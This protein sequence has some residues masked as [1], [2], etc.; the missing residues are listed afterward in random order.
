MTHLKFSLSLTSGNM[1]RNAEDACSRFH[2]DPSDRDRRHLIA[3][4]TSVDC[5]FRGRYLDRMATF[6]DNSGDF[7]NSCNKKTIIFKMPLIL[8]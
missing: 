1:S 8:L 6:A 7:E 4:R 2:F 5:P 3:D